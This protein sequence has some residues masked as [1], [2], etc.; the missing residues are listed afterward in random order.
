MNLIIIDIF[1]SINILANI[2]LIYYAFMVISNEGI[3]NFKEEVK[4]VFAIALAVVIFM[5]TKETLEILLIN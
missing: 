2:L 1:C 4:L 3:P 5:P